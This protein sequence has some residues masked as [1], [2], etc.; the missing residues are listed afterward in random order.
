MLWTHCGYET[1]QN[2]EDFSIR[3]LNSK[4][5]TDIPSN[6]PLVQQ[7]LQDLRWFDLQ[8]ACALLPHSLPAA[9]VPLELQQKW[10]LAKHTT[11]ER[12]LHRKRGR[13][14]SRTESLHHQSSPRKNVI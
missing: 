10:D 4:Y 5:K 8:L 6:P 2:H 11:P 12:L 13:D 14:I 1:M 3:S 9:G 7:L